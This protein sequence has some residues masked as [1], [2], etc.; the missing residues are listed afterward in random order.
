MQ[1]RLLRR[2][3]IF[4]SVGVFFLFFTNILL[5]SEVAKLETKVTCK[6]ARECVKT[7]C[8][9]D[10]FAR[11]DEVMMRYRECKAIAHNN[12]KP[13]D[14][15]VVIATIDDNK[16]IFYSTIHL[17]DAKELHGMCKVIASMT[18]AEYA[19]DPVTT[20]ISGYLGSYS[21]DSYLEA[22][23]ANNPLLVLFPANIPGNKLTKDV[24]TL[25]GAQG[26]ID[27]PEKIAKKAVDKAAEHVQK[28]PEDLVA[29]TV[30]VPYREGKK[31]LEK[32]F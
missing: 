20:T 15:V 16:K 18:A 4:F 27:Y 29:P 11:M 23:I 30:T 24:L 8:W 5:A 32:L 1:N 6:E 13:N 3:V 10:D 26:I 28:N 9:D 19:G 21:C 25:L 2:W 14:P 31:I 17:K 12:D 7:E 22:A